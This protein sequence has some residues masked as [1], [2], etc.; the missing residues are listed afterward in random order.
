VTLE[1]AQT[2]LQLDAAPPELGM[3]IT[4]ISVRIEAHTG[5]WFVAR[6][7]TD[8]L[9][10]DGGLLLFL[11]RYPVQGVPVVTDLT[12]GLAVTDF[13][14]YPERGVLYR[15]AGWEAGRR[16][17]RVEYTAGMCQD[18]ASV[19][20]DVKQ[21]CLE[22]LAARYNRRD[23]S[24]QREQLGDYS[25]AADEKEGMPAGVKAALSLYR[26]PRGC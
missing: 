6:A 16:R 7:V 11:S 8:I 21:A 12:T 14:L 10:A 24:L 3:L 1:E 13:L 2:Y 5:R 25:Y 17:Y 15:G 23:P 20:T 9:D 4:N 18:T 19:P 26:L 22:W